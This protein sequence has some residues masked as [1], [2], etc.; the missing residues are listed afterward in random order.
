MK[1]RAAVADEAGKAL[2][3]ETVDLAGP[4]AGEVLWRSRLRAFATPMRTHLRCRSEGLF[5]PFQDMRVPG[6]E[7]ALA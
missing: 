3:I 7:I 5:R 2:S 1:V 4:K 6:S